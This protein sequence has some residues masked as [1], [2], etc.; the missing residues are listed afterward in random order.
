MGDKM[1]NYRPVHY[2]R[3]DTMTLTKTWTTGFRGEKTWLMLR[4][5]PQ[6]GH[7]PSCLIP[8]PSTLFLRHTHLLVSSSRHFLLSLPS[9]ST[10]FSPSP[11]PSGF[12]PSIFTLPPVILTPSPPRHTFLVSTRH[13]L[14]FLPSFLRSSP[15]PSISCHSHRFFTITILAITIRGQIKVND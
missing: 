15:P 1:G 11:I 9:L 3:P 10:L 4:P 8:S 14:P 7:P 12:F 2:L 6:L 13:F 5:H